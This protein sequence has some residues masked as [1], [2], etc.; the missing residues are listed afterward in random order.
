M[1]SFTILLYAIAPLARAAGLA[2]SPVKEADSLIT[3]PP[4]Y[5]AG[6]ALRAGGLPG[7]SPLRRGPL[8]DG[9]DAANPVEKRQVL[10]TT[11]ALIGGNP[12]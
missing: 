6:D 8:Y 7:M 4:P 11:C 3:P 5:P 2:P 1:K 9:D 12:S 10:A